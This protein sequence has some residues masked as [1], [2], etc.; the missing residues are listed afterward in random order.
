M[1][2]SKPKISVIMPV[3]NAEL[4][5]KKSIDSILNQ[6]IDNFEFIIIND[7]STDNT[8]NIIKSYNDKRIKIINNRINIGISGSLNKGK[9]LAAGEYIARQDADDISEPN[10][11]LLQLKYLDENNLDLVDTNIVFIDQE[12]N[13][14]QDYTS[15][16]YAP[17]E[18]LSHLFFYEINHATILCKRKF[19]EFNEIDYQ[20]RP[21][22]DYDFFL[23]LALLG[24]KS[25]HMIEPLVK[26]RKYEESLC[27]SN[28]LNIKKDINLRR[29]NLLNEIKLKP[30]I[31]LEKIHI[32]LVDQ[33]ISDLLNYKFIDII[34]WCNSI[35]ESNSQFN[36]FNDKYMKK[37]LYSRLLKI[38]KF[39]I[40]TSIKDIF[41]LWKY[42]YIY[43][44]SLSLRD[45]F[46]LYRYGK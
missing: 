31:K 39:N 40:K 16:F 45:F 1:N 10:R 35:L 18:T 23:N 19:L 37:E 43:E 30:N 44:K 27:G 11:F 46:Y 28:W 21:A 7:G 2:Y 8:L 6:T 36:I 41:Y 25:G 42:A 33:N 14:I 38:I 5:L 20:S 3:F 22:E 13:Y 17:N 29:I 12:D 4:F 9:A 26:V 15:R 34:N 32:A 24:M